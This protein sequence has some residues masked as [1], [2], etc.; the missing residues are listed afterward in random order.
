M[1]AFWNVGFYEVQFIIYCMLHCTLQQCFSRGVFL[2]VLRP[3]LTVLHPARIPCA[4]PD[5]HSALSE[6]KKK[7]SF[8]T[9]NYIYIYILYNLCFCVLRQLMNCEVLADLC[10]MPMF[11]SIAHKIVPICRFVCV[12]DR[13]R[14]LVIH[15]VVR[16]IN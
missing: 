12:L 1:C 16:V 5:V 7:V 13:A 8:F 2:R 14:I 10:P 3:A 6:L 15:L 11:S 4:L 9:N